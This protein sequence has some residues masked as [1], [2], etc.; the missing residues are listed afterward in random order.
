MQFLYFIED[1]S[2]FS[3]KFLG[4]ESSWYANTQV[5]REKDAPFVKEK[6]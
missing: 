3:P 6:Y 2:S 4:Q 5:D 1:G